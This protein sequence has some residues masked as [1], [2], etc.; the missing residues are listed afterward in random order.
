MGIE[1]YFTTTFNLTRQKWVGDSASELSKGSF[2]GHMQQ[3]DQEKLTELDIDLALAFT[4]WCDDSTNIQEG[5]VI[6]DGTYTYTVKAVMRNNFVGK[7]KHK[8]VLVDRN[9]L[10]ISR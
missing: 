1:R 3:A 2:L 10:P 6:D 5:D 8:E 9:K 4:V 7:N